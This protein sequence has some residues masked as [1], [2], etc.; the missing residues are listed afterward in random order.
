M[1]RDGFSLMEVIVAMVVLSVGILALAGIMGT[2]TRVQG[3]SLNRVEM[4]AVAE[5]QM[6]QLRFAASRGAPPAQQAQLAVGGSLTS[7]LAGY[8]ATM[9]AGSGRTYLVRWQVQEGPVG[10]NDRAV[11]LRVIPSTAHLHQV[12]R[13]DFQTILFLGE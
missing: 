9:N 4:A 13:L 7:S 6:E 12:A 11:T 3:I 8:H 5:R 10:F 2:T 1:N